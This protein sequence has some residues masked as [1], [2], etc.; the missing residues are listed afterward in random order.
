MV[1]H[2]FSVIKA[3]KKVQ[4]SARIHVMWDHA[5]RICAKTSVNTHHLPLGLEIG[6]YIPCVDRHVQGQR[7]RTINGNCGILQVS[8]TETNGSASSKQ[9]SVCRKLD[10]RIADPYIFNLT[11]NILHRNKFLEFLWIP[12]D[13]LRMVR[14][15]AF[16][17]IFICSLII[18]PRHHSSQKL[19]VKSWLSEVVTSS[20]SVLWKRGRGR[21]MGMVVTDYR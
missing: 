17:I 3:K 20:R 21:G 10:L 11:G 9:R 1:E 12:F 18:F 7:V 19:E 14:P 8:K 5:T 2:N 13:F 4:L 6:G 16:P 15:L